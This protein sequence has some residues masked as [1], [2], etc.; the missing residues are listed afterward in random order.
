MMMALRSASA[1]IVLCFVAG[2]ACSSDD[3]KALPAPDSSSTTTT[4]AVVN[5]SEVALAPITPGKAPPVTRPPGPGKASI[6][7]K[8]VDTSGA[9]VPQA[10]VRASYFF[11]PAKPE[12]IE[13]LSGDDGTY[14]FDRLYGG[15][16]RIRAWKAPVLATLEQPAFFLGATEQKTLE[17]KVKAV[18]DL[19][20]TSKMAP[21]PPLVGWPAELAVLVV[22]QTVDPE[23]KVLRTPL[24]ATEVTLTT[25]SSWSLGGAA[26]TKPTDTDGTARWTMSCGDEGVHPA[27]LTVTARE[28]P[29]TL[30]SC[31][32]PASTTTATTTTTGPLSST[33]STK[34]KPKTTTTQPRSTSSTRPGVRPR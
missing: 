21:D 33:S 3:G 29:L 10:L 19:E 22:S 25:G 31:L 27:S 24:G 14:R 13:A 18:P 12:V 7:G 23:G 26:A 6:A 9:P 17:L 5:L 32:S 34:P 20:V 2:A 11:D 28:F 30:P 4:T 16:W 15:R 8:V 1:V